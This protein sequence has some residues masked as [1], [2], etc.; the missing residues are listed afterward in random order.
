[1]KYISS[2][3]APDVS[4][5]C[6][7]CTQTTKL[8]VWSGKLNNNHTCC[9]V[10]F[11]WLNMFFVKGHVG[12]EYWK[13]RIDT[14][15]SLYQTMHV[16]EALSVTIRLESINYWQKW[17]TKIIQLMFACVMFDASFFQI[18]PKIVFIFWYLFVYS[19]V[20]RWHNK[21]EYVNLRVL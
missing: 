21:Y 20:H 3:F 19:Y 12:T 7:Q 8:T 14:S 16:N 9:V 6:P 15:T 1:M 2:C 4:L 13:C 10:G 18:S 11:L 5:A 17:N